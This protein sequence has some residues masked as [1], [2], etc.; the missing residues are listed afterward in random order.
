MNIDAEFAVTSAQRI[1]NGVRYRAKALQERPLKNQIA[2][3]SKPQ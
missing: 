1:V 2:A 3:L